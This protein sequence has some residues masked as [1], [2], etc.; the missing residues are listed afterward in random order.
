MC[1]KVGVLRG[2]LEFSVVLIVLS[3]CV[4]VVVFSFVFCLVA[5]SISLLLLLFQL[6]LSIIKLSEFRSRYVHGLCA[7]KANH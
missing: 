6:A 7:E 5:S 3:C 4:N 1:C 2:G